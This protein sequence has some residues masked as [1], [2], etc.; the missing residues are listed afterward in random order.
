MLAIKKVGYSMFNDVGPLI[1]I[2]EFK[3]F[4]WSLQ[5]HSGGSGSI[6]I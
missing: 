5:S 3:A 1:E 6:E 4:D 2:W